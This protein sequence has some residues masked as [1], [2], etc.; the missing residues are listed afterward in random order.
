MTQE[1]RPRPKVDQAGS[2]E[3]GR[4]SFGIMERAID[5][6]ILELWEI[7]DTMENEK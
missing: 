4:R 2:E 1:T 6:G 3:Q 7:S 5:L